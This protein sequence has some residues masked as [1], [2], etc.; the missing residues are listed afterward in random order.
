MTST[1][2]FA[3]TAPTTS[4]R[5]RTPI[6]TTPNGASSLPTSAGCSVGSTRWWRRKAP[7]LT[8]LTCGRTRWCASSVAST[9]PSSCS[10]GAS[11]PSRC[12]CTF[13]ASLWWLWFSATSS[14]T[15]SRCTRRGW[16]TR[17][18]ISAAGSSTIRRC[19][20]GRIGWSPISRW[21][22]VSDC[23]KLKVFT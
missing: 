14:A 1:N 15:S 10:F 19:S 17:R 23:P 6:R 22:K 8:C 7:R 3:T 13:G 5:R 12:R 11:F 9:F 4:T 21:A 18:P 16:S 2:G 20:Q